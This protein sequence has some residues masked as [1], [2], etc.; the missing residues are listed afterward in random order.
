[1]E[2]VVFQSPKKHRIIAVKNLLIENNIPI[3]SVK[4]RIYVAWST[5]S[6]KTNTGK[7]ETRES[8]DELNVPIEEFSEKLNDAQIF[9]LYTDE[10][11]EDAAAELI[12]N[13]DEETFFDDCIFRSKNYDEAIE[14]YMLLNKNNIPCDDV[15]TSVD[16]YLLFIDPENKDEAAKIIEQNNKDKER[17]YEYQNIKPNETIFEEYHENNIFK[18]ILPFLFGLCILLFRIDNKFIFEIIIKKIVE[19]IKEFIGVL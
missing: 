12:E 19:V 10:K 8:C 3:T 6:R 7:V 11:Y 18:Y 9:E 1:M 17:T 4:I 15:S 13:C 5:Y 2:T 16:E 14:I